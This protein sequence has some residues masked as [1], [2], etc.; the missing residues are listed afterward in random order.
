M[1]ILIVARYKTAFPNHIMPFVVEQGEALRSLGNEVD[2]VEAT[3]DE[4]D[5]VVS[6]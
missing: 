6:P 5:R 4:E 2:Y 1:R 3:I